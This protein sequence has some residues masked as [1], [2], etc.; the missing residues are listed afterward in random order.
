MILH[1]ILPSLQLTIYA[2]DKATVAQWWD[3]RGV[4]SPFTRLF[5]T[6]DGHAEI[7]H[8]GKTYPLKPGTV[9]VAPPYVPVDY[10]CSGTC[11]SFYVLFTAKLTGGIELFS[12]PGFAWTQSVGP[13]TAAHWDRLMALNPDRGLTLYDPADRSYDDLI[14]KGRG[15]P[16]S[17]GAQLETD[18]ILRT[19]LAPFV[20]SLGETDIPMG[21]GRLVDVLAYIDDHLSETIDLADMA[22]VACLNPTYFSDR[23]LKQMGVRP[24]VYLKSKRMEKAQLL[25]TTTS[26]AIKAI[27]HDVGYSDTDYFFRVFKKAVGMTPSNYRRQVG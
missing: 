9:T 11:E 14:W 2:L 16:S 13:L 5:Y 22:R 17:K 15:Y 26:M 7:R 23:F 18:G 10:H 1:E 4:N 6:V 19:L 3:Y 20:D 25:M 21:W 12:L 27:A 8:E 24:T